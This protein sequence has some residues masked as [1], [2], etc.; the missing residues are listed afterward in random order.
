ME[1]IRLKVA[2]AYKVSRM[3]SFIDEDIK[4]IKKLNQ[5]YQRLEKN[6]KDIYILEIINIL[7]M[8][9][10]VFDVEKL[11]DVLYELI[12]IRYYNTIF[13]LFDKIDYIDKT[14]YKKLQG[15]VDG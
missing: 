1:E 4:L 3:S 11:K 2:L 7:K 5:L 8:L 12:D 14:D 9:I 6:K 10:N 15:L 13:Y